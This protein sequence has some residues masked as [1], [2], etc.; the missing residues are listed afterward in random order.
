VSPFWT[1]VQ[2]YCTVAWSRRDITVV[3]K[4]A[5]LALYMM[6]EDALTFEMRLVLAAVRAFVAE[7]D[8]DTVGA[9]PALLPLR[10]IANG[11]LDGD[12][13]HAARVLAALDTAGLIGTDTMGWH[14]GWITEKGKRA[15]LDLPTEIK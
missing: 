12:A 10:R 14:R 6:V 13:Q 3:G 8:A 4:R 1:C 2:Y 15:P 9:N 5:I 7:R 11:T